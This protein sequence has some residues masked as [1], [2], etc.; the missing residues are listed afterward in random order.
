MTLIGMELGSENYGVAASV[1]YLRL[2]VRGEGEQV[3]HDYLAEIRKLAEV[4]AQKEAL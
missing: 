3:F 2:T 1:G 4:M